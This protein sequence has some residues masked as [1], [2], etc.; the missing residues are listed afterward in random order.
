MKTNNT[1]RGFTQSRHAEF[2][3]ASSRFTKGFTLIELLV[4]VLIIGILAAIAVPQYQKAVQKARLSE[5]GAVAKSAQ[6][7][8][9]A[10][11]L[12]NGGFPEETTMFTGTNNSGKLDIDI[13]GTPCTAA[14]N[15]IKSGAYDIGCTSAQ[16]GIT[17]Q[18]QY[19]ADGTTGNTWL[20]EGRISLLRKPDDSTWYL[21]IVPSDIHARKVVCQWWNGPTIDA[22]EISSLFTAKTDCAEVGVE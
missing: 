12:E 4:V 20:Q 8:I 3:S 16:C 5:F 19:N 6:Q 17:L 18:T 10:W 11:L 15:C 21:T 1:R 7:P 9:D 13:P 2:I 14:K 22:T